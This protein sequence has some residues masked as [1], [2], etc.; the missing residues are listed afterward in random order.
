MKLRPPQATSES[1]VTAPG[2]AVSPY[3]TH[4]PA[5]ELSGKLANSATYTD[6]L[7]AKISTYMFFTRDISGNKHAEK[8]KMKE[9][10][11]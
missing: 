3:Y 4:M 1:P 10:K 5:T 11:R 8:L 2:K 6:R 9:Y 7:N